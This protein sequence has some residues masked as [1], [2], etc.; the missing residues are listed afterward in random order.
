MS[1][2]PSLPPSTPRGAIA[3]QSVPVTP[4]GRSQIREGTPDMDPFQVMVLY[5]FN[6]TESRQLSIKMH[7]KITILKVHPKGW[8]IAE[9]AKGESG[10]IPSNYVARITGEEEPKKV[11]KPNVYRPGLAG[12][13][14]T[15]SKEMKES[16]GIEDAGSESEESEEDSD[17]EDQDEVEAV[18][19]KLVSED[20]YEQLRQQLEKLTLE[21]D[22]LNK[23]L[24]DERD[25]NILSEKKNKMLLGQIKKRSTNSPVGTPT[26]AQFEELKVELD[27]KQ[28]ELEEKEKL[29]KEREESM[30]KKREEV[31]AAARKIESD[32][33]KKPVPLKT[34]AKPSIKSGKTPTTPSITPSTPTKS[35]PSN[36]SDIA[37][38]KLQDEVR[39][40]QDENSKLKTTSP[41]VSPATPVSGRNP[42]GSSQNVE[43][44]QQIQ[45]LQAEVKQLES[46]L[47]QAQ[48]EA[49]KS[50]SASLTTSQNNTEKLDQIQAQ[51]KQAQ[52]DLKQSQ[53]DLNKSKQEVQAKEK[54]ADQIKKQLEELNE[55]YKTDMKAA[56]EKLN[57]KSNTA[58]AAQINTLKKVRDRLRSMKKIQ[59]DLKSEVQNHLSLLQADMKQLKDNGVGKLAS[60][61]I[62]ITQ[63]YNKEAKERRKLFNELQ[64]LKGNIRVYV[65]VRPILPSDGSTQ[66]S[67]IETGIDEI[68]V[69]NV[70]EKKTFKYEFEKV[71]GVE[72]MQS[73]VFEDV[74]PL[75]TSILD[76]YNVCI[77]AYGQT[78][79]GKTHTM[80][81]NP[82]DRGVNY[83]TLSELFRIKEERKQDFS[84]DINVAVMEI[85]NETL[86][87]LLGS[88]KE[89]EKKKLEILMSKEISVP[90]LLLVPVNSPEDV[91]NTLQGGYKSRAVG[92]NNINEHSSRSHCIV[93]VYVT[94]I[95]LTTKQK[96]IGKLHLID[97]AGSE[98]LKRTETTGDRMKESMAINKS[99]SALGDVIS[100]LASK[101]PHIPFRNSKLTSLL[102]D[103]L[104]GNS[105]TLMFVNVSPTIESCPETLCSLGFAARV[106]TVEMGKAEKN[107]VKA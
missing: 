73:Q 25:K 106:K 93:S 102:Q 20:K 47:K 22:E 27:L 79:S 42:L 30:Q 48:D 99:L 97:L 33:T 85:Y 80:E 19:V 68:R 70:E 61:V 88:S 76:G 38:K 56:T 13:D 72:S 67:C 100:A 44:T 10:L 17:V 69:R 65:R 26:S 1:Q 8:W 75:A 50:Q 107:T 81:G 15:R 18:D 92:A 9:N 89:K 87:D 64:D 101:K 24:D 23:Q 4:R 66:G 59:K 2:A 28:Q 5:S 40:L 104:G 94:A 35:G 29:I 46:K 91:I 39:K 105:K 37:L 3:G 53:T 98:R 55:K 32:K 51:L 95:N 77:F 31:E 57:Q 54:E 21:K 60:A 83:R 43:Q 84:F 41:V 86:F 36:S 63:K 12:S 14:V 45:Q 6:A 90:G 62:D 58:S 49:K 71:F 7:E 82:K 74:K 34:T 16:L 52:Q 96:T 11:M 78:G 103:S